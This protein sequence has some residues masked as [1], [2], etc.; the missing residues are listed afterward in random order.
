MFYFLI[1]RNCVC[2]YL[3]FCVLSFKMVTKLQQLQGLE[4]LALLLFPSSRTE[5][6]LMERLKFFLSTLPALSPTV[7]YVSLEG[8]YIYIFF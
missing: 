3:M 8:Q 1:S 4:S 5:N 6:F 7:S 2:V